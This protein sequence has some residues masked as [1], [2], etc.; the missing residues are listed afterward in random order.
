MKFSIGA[1]LSNYGGAA[2]STPRNGWTPVKCPF[3]EDR[4]A[5][6]SVHEQDGRFHCFVCGIYED[7]VG[8]IM[9]RERVEFSDAVSE[10][11]A[12]TSQSADT[13]RDQRDLGGW[14]PQRPR[15]H[16]RRSAKM[17]AWRGDITA[18]LT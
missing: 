7:A 11:E 4:H 6:A 9:E 16:T 8:L 2:P 17:G 13:I 5:S 10:A 1:I 3:H 18:A 12:I 14:F 15:A